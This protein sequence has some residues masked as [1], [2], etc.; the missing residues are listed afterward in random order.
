[1]NEIQK[2]AYQKAAEKYSQLDNFYKAYQTE[3]EGI[4]VDKPDTLQKVLKMLAQAKQKFDSLEVDIPEVEDREDGIENPMDDTKLLV[5]NDDESI[6]LEAKNML[7]GPITKDN[8]TNIKMAFKAILDN[9]ARDNI[10]AINLVCDYIREKDEKGGSLEMTIIKQALAKIPIAGKFVTVADAVVKNAYLF[11]NTQMTKD[12]YTLSQFQD[13]STS[14]WEKYKNES[15][16]KEVN[17]FLGEYDL[18]RISY[19]RMEIELNLFKKNLPSSLVLKKAFVEA[20]VKSSKDG[21]D[22]N[23]YAGII[24]FSVHYDSGAKTFSIGTKPYFDDIQRDKGVIHALGILYSK[25]DTIDKLPFDLKVS[26]TEEDNAA[27]LFSEI[28]YAGG[29]EKKWNSSS[30]SWLVER[31]GISS[32]EVDEIRYLALRRERGAGCI[33][34]ANG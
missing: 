14:A 28:D 13:E 10:D 25:T 6:P 17:E 31:R 27:N 5:S 16:L 15:H 24:C 23:S 7:L 18:D 11:F 2:E 8:L 33:V 26:F 19:Q 3:L 20:W 21:V 12:N 22:W 29:A 1:M 32:S 4:Y 30:S 9:W 34:V